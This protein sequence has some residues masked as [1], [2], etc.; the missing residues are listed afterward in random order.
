[1]K[2]GGILSF[3]GDLYLFNFSVAISAS[4]EVG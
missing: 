1:M 2:V 4:K 3:P